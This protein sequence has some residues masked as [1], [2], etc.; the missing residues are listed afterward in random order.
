MDV[1]NLPIGT[2]TELTEAQ[3][4][5]VQGSSK[6]E[7]M[8]TRIQ[9]GCPSFHARQPPQCTLELREGGAV[10]F[11]LMRSTRGELP[12]IFAERFQIGF[13]V[14]GVRLTC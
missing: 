5:C 4:G 12:S 11:G 3:H 8:M 7:I 6:G 9:D 13:D 1:A 2:V 10:E 14:E